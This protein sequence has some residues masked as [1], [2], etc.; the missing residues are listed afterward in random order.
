MV[1]MRA[2]RKLRREYPKD[3]TRSP[4]RRA[5][6]I[7]V[8]NSTPNH[9]NIPF[10]NA[11]TTLTLGFPPSSVSSC[12]VTRITTLRFFARAFAHSR[13]TISAFSTSVSRRRMNILRDKWPRGRRAAKQRSQE[14]SSS[15]V[16]CH[17]TLRLGG[18]H[19]M[20]DDTTLPSRG[21]H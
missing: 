6:G 19:A 20:E 3:V 12:T 10:Q 2:L 15:D 21:S 1:E 9:L 14:F 5:A 8:D 16:A 13:S 4:R 7:D 11:I 18:I 17:V